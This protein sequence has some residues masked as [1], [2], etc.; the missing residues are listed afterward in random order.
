[1]KLSSQVKNN[2]K[3][4]IIIILKSKKKGST[5]SCAET[6]FKAIRPKPQA[7]ENRL[8][9][10]LGCAELEQIEDSILIEDRKLQLL[11]QK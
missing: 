9:L 6:K 10:W 4:I 11:V 5:K 1:M 3:I 7:R 8:I 2:V